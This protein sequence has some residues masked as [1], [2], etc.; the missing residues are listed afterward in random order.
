MVTEGLSR[1]SFLKGAAAVGTVGA[2]A[3]ALAGCSSNTTSN[4]TDTTTWDKEADVV[5]L[6]DGASGLSAA[7]SAADAGAS[8]IVLEKASAEEEGGNTRV[9]G[10]CW[11]I[12]KD[13]TKGFDYYKDASELTGDVEDTYLK[14]LATDLV[15]INDDFVGDLPDMDLTVSPIFSPEQPALAG[16]DTLVCYV[17]KTAGDGKLWESLR[18]GAASYDNIEIVN[19]CPGKELVQNS[20]GEVIGVLAAPSSGDIKVKAKRGVIVATGGYEFDYGM[21]E[22][23]YPGWPTYSR[24]TPYNT[25]DGIKMCQKVGATLWHMNASDA[26]GCAMVCQGLDFGG[27]D[28]DSDDVTANCTLAAHL[29]WINVDKYG[30]RFMPEDRDDRHGYG[31]REYVYW[32]DGIKCEWPRLPYWSVF[33]DATAKAGPIGK[34]TGTS[35]MS[36]FTW[37]AAH[38]G[39]SWSSDN[40]AEVAKGWILKG[41]TIE[42]LAGKME[43][44][45]SVLAQTVTDYNGYCTLGSDPEFGRTDLT[46]VGAGPYYAFKSYPTQYNTQGGPKRNEKAQT[47]DPFDAPIPRLYSVGECG[48]GWGW[49]YNGGFNLAEA[50]QTGLWAGANAAA[51]SD[52]DA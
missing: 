42:E 49:V 40:S 3:G 32:Y 15:N 19:E 29:G 52:W 33:D 1:R 18:A 24:G 35:M 34:G 7:M 8:V 10:N 17:N 27:G 14:A 45:P 31:K 12:P 47:L 21:I 43:V 48:A 46:P 39:Y 30:K 9:S 36:T 50:M 44:D 20:A 23:S 37:F 41:D 26:G 38:S 5:V 11:T 16:G 4:G 28:Y 22:N 51:L 25:G 6:G 2:F 13:A